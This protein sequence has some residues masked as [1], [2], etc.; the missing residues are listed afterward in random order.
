VAERQPRLADVAARAGVS[1]ATASRVLGGSRDRVSEALA[2]RV[3][4]AAR[5]LN[6]VPNAQA[7][8]LARASSTTIGLVVHDVGDPYFSEIA[9]GV[10][11]VASSEGRLVLICNAYRDPERELQYVLE[12]RSQRVHAI[13]MAGSGYTDPAAE[14]PLARELLAFHSAGGAVALIGRHQAALDTVQPDNVGGAAAVGGWL[15]AHGHRDIAV[16]AGP[17]T[18]TT[19]EDRLAGL[20]AGL[21][22]HSVQLA[23]DR[24][25]HVDFTRD[26]GYRATCELL[27]NGRPF[28]ALVALN[29][30]MAIGGLIA[31]R[32]RSVK[33][34]DEVSVVGFDDI[35]YAADVTPSLTTVRIPLGRMGAD[36]VRLALT[37]RAD[38]RPQH[39]VKAPSELIVRDSTGPAPRAG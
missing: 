30:A 5:A 10:L 25:R 33:V 12:L 17:P 26:G 18:L 28:T 21:D 8:A 39:I 36:A 20:Q 4:D 31:C 11:S 23:G 19:I 1:L 32:D 14:E 15:A 3:I 29:D 7:K 37:Q 9:R 16:V 2:E 34:P 38:D 35:P 22:T 27:D 24:V 6:Y 13:L